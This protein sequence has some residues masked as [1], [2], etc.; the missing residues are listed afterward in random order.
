MN[1]RWQANKI[2]LI[3]FWY[4]DEQEFS[5][6]KGRMLLRGSN[7]SG[8][9]VTMQSVVPLLLDGNLSPERLDPFGSRDRKMSSYLLE[10]DDER[11]ER[12]GYLYLEFKRQESDAYMTV[13]MGI[14]AR[15]GKP[16]DKWYFSITDG[17]RIG[18]DF[19]LY[20]ETDE[21]V[22]LSKKEL[23]N[24]L[25]NGGQIF[26]RQAE[27]ME[28][29]NRQI[30]GFETPEEYKEMVDLLIQLRTPKL[31]K[32]FKPSVINDI[33]SDSLQPLSD[34]DLRPMS[35]A[36]ENMDTMNLNLKARLEGQQ[37]A[38]KIHRVLEKYNR[39]L[40]F[41]KCANYQINQKN[42]S[43]LEKDEKELKR[44]LLNCEKR[45][46]ELTMEN[47]GLNAQKEAMEKERDSLNKSDAVALK[48]KE[49]DLN[50][51]IQENETSLTNKKDQ[52]KEKQESYIQIE[53]KKKEEENKKYQKETDLNELL[54]EMQD[55]AEEMAFE[56]HV[57]FSDELKKEF[58]KVFSFTSHENQ[59]KVTQIRIEEG[60]RILQEVD[61][62]QRHIES[63][64]QKKDEKQRE[65]DAA[66]RSVN[67]LESVFVQVQNEWKES[68][69]HWNSNNQELTISHEQL[70][71]MSTSIEGYDQKF[72]FT[73]IRS[74]AA[75][76]YI[77]NKGTLETLKQQSRIREQEQQSSYEQQ[78]K[79]LEEWELLKEPE[80]YRSE[81]VQKNRRRL[82][83]KG[84][85]YHEFYKVVEFGEN[86]DKAACDRLEEALSLMGILDALIVEE[87]YKEQ[88]LSLDIGA[89]DK[90]LF[91]QKQRAEKSVLDVLELNDS[92]NDIFFNQQITGL[93]ENIAYDG[94]GITAIDTAGRYQL[95]VLTGTIT[96]EYEAGF[97]GT[98]AR[99]KNRQ[100]KIRLCKEVMQQLQEEITK[101]QEL[102]EMLQKRMAILEG[103]YENFP[104]EQDVRAAFRMLDEGRRKE[105][106]LKK[107]VLEIG[108]ELLKK[109]EILKEIKLEALALAEKLYLNCTLEIFQTADRAMRDYTQFFYQ[110][111]SGHEAYLQIESSIRGLEERLES[112]DLDLDQIRYEFGVIERTLRKEKAEYDSIQ[113]QMKLTD[114]E[115]IK[116]R[117]DQCMQWLGGYSERL[118]AC[119]RE[120]TETRDQAK[121]IHVRIEE[122]L[123]R[124]AVYLERGNYLS[125]Y[126]EAE[127]AL[128]YVKIPEELG[129]DLTKIY[130]YLAVDSRALDK[131]VINGDLNRV[132]YEN[133]GFLT[134]YQVMQVELFSDLDTPLE[135]T[136]PS[137]KRI[138]YYAR[139]QGV[140]IPFHQLLVYLEQEIEDLQDLLKDGDR[141]LFEDIL[142]NTVS[143]KIRGKI[144]G[145]NSWVEKMNRLM[146]AMNTS[147]GLKLSLRWRSKTAETEDQL[148]TKELVDLLKKDYR[149]MHED[150]AGK[151]SLHFRS[152]VEEARRHAKDSAGTMSFY[153]VM[154]DTL[155]YR[156]WFEFQLFSQKS[157][158][159]VK[160]LT[161]SVFGTFSGGEKAM[162][163]YV[164]LFSAVV[165][166]YQGGRQ[167]AP[168]MISLDEA[169]AG[170]DNK[171]I[172]DMFRLMTEFEF[173]FIINSQ[174]LWGDC[175]TLDALAIYQLLRPENA[176]F[177]TVMPYLWN[178][179][180]KELLEDERELEERAE[181]FA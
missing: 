111:K 129:D 149:L 160:E 103:E 67:E 159:R 12:T 38:L 16:L 56:E 140:K 174:V 107:E 156:K 22:T 118:S 57:F 117:L 122:G 75:D 31:S 79:E 81:A 35:E 76:T 176:K 126:Y 171:N 147:S 44:D 125:R 43:A 108:Q 177:V 90:Y 154:R 153:Q 110:L 178:G 172:R 23:E 34:D 163:M 152:K 54:D 170:V 21:K 48:A 84:I 1:S 2:G 130:E 55:K 85:P 96:G 151:L 119:V 51:R 179:K 65:A 102:Q 114:Y 173:D 158:E 50:A 63:L 66:S 86:L 115:E 69:Y 180:T 19:Y 8:K 155:D 30:F 78:H 157:G 11:E 28:Y 7:G 40:L 104:G 91:V 112:L 101:E 164:P 169:F 33:L 135:G 132:Y 36:I 131:G 123:K 49:L 150:E 71:E 109:S 46:Q 145:S 181:Q 25:Q 83:E 77:Q 134:D 87:Q 17:R 3:N 32:D 41:E 143:R 6:V 24:R 94:D 20:K 127:K 74:K 137:P 138:D 15:K 146:G 167:D 105:E 128:Q 141:E 161:N 88:V 124:K 162:S 59:M 165:A 99:E 92:V 37:A 70:K 89:C 9:S 10:E 52:L 136:V 80:P 98:K 144:N 82:K 175:D 13:G 58:H 53:S 133:R 26:D 42:L 72:D 93:L 120:E 121:Q 166:K 106:Q 142:A 39:V 47:Q 97:V 45:I 113:E 5:F 139:Y 116:E 60:L 62:Q 100:E 61:M 168:R 18:K 4:Y 73:S 64:I 95:G 29:V 148:D 14:R 68:L 27:Y